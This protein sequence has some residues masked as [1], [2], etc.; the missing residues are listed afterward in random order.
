MSTEVENSH[1]QT[2][3]HLLRSGK[4]PTE[5]AKELGR[6]RSWCYKWKE[7]FRQASWAGLKE[8][9]RA[10]HH[11]ARKT[12]ERIRQVILRTRSELEAEAL[13]VDDL[14][15]IGANAI[16]GRLQSQGMVS[17]PSVSTIER[18]LRQAGA[19]KPRQPKLVKEVD[20]PTLHANVV[21]QLTQVDI[22]PHYLQGGMSIACFN[23]I[24]VVSRFPAGKQYQNKRSGEVL[25]FL[26]YIW[27]EMG[28]SEYLQFDNESCFSGGYK[29]PGVIGQ[30]VRLALH[31]G[32]QP[33]FSPIYHP[34]SNAYVERFHQDYSGFVWKKAIMAG[35]ADVRKRS[36]LFF[37]NYRNSHHHSG[38]AGKSP[39]QIHS[40]TPIRKL[41]F[42]FC[43]PKKLPITEGQVHFMRPVTKER[44]VLILNKIWDVKLA[45]QNQGVWATL[46]L[47]PKSAALRI[48]DAVPGAPNRRCLAEHP[49]PLKEPV[50]PLQAIF[51][52]AMQQRKSWIHA[53][54]DF[55]QPPIS[56]PSTMS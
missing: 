47:T 43:A 1:R 21:H 36:G 22:V 51:K 2:L 6:S 29:H 15:Y 53:I 34:E 50:V 40:Q 27:R 56:T 9:S 7:R 31:V 16:F 42:G 3:V 17:V 19:V 10:P 5:A 18:I 54:R 26:V 37:P 25:D 39:L 32:T 44:Q 4:T 35:L 55:F 20:Y 38:L 45:E 24:D 49:F 30:A 52:P 23:A 41:P 28:I 13:Q 12:S 8:R 33:V 48:Y 14:S 11:I 46:F